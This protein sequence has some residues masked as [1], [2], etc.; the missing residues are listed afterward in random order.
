[1]KNLFKVFAVVFCSV[2][3][4][5]LSLPL[6][7]EEKINNFEVHFDLHENNSATVKEYITFTSEHNQIE[8]GL[9]RILPKDIGRNIKIESLTLDG[10]K[11]PYNR[12]EGE[13]SLKI[14]FCNCII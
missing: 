5:A 13:N 3:C 11:H 9:Y 2:L 10:E 6:A 4:L 1:M 14:N 12:E 7:A 8:H